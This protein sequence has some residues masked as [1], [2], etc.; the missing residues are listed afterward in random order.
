MHEAGDGSEEAAM[1]DVTAGDGRRELLR[2][3]NAN[4]ARISIWNVRQQRVAQAT[5]GALGETTKERTQARP[6]SSD[7]TAFVAPRGWA[8]LWATGAG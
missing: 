3:E 7:D 4:A 6:S 1:A 5:V 2:V 8:V